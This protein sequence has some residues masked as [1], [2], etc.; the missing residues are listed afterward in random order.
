MFMANK[1][2][3]AVEEEYGQPFWDVVRDFAADGYAIA[4]VSKI[5]GYKTGDGL[6]YQ[7]KKHG[8]DIDWPAQAQ[9]VVHKDPG[10]QTEQHKQNARAAQMAARETVETRYFEKTGETILDLLNRLH[11]TTN[12]QTVAKIAGWKSHQ[13]LHK[14][15]YTRGIKLEFFR[16]PTR[17]PKG[18]GLQSPEYKSISYGKNMLTASEK[19]ARAQY[20][21]S[22]RSELPSLR[23]FV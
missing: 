4:T 21:A 6:R 11:R 16:L 17:P 15:M 9:S 8:I 14:W 22:R 5:L 12:A 13:G 1:V 2:I 10:P 19:K 7:I 20:L 3:K 18:M 23:D